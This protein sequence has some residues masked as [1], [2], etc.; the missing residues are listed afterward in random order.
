ME[1][2]FWKITLEQP[3]KRIDVLNIGF[4]KENLTALAAA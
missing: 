1:Y 4:A 3:Y 2:F